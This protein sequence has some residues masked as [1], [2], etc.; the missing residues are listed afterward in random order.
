MKAAGGLHLSSS[1]L[2]TS[3][4][5]QSTRRSISAAFSTVGSTSQSSL[6]SEA[7]RN[8]TAAG[9]SRS[10]SHRPGGQ[11]YRKVLGVCSRIF[12]DGTP[13]RSDVWRGRLK[14][15]EKDLQKASKRTRIAGMSG[16]MTTMRRVSDIDCYHHS[17][18]C[19]CKRHSRLSYLPLG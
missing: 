18:W 6:D 13:L 10:L 12:E 3:L 19:H 16:L 15:A 11:E 5:R 9:P 1:Y 7:S 2:K 4:N 8:I 14:R 17:G